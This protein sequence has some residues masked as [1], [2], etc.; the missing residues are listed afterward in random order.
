MV[1][2]EVS[3]ATPNLDTCVDCGGRV[4]LVGVSGDEDGAFELYECVEC[5]GTGSYRNEFYGGD[6]VSTSGVIR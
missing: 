2:R 5:G 4:E 1:L 6:G 3:D